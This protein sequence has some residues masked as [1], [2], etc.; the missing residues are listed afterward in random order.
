M[1][2]TNGC[3]QAL[4]T[5]LRRRSAVVLSS[6]PNRINRMPPASASPSVAT[7]KC[8]APLSLY[9]AGPHITGLNP[10]GPNT[11]VWRISVLLLIVARA[12]ATLAST[13]AGKRP[14]E[15]VE[16]GVVH[17]IVL[18]F[19]VRRLRQVKYRL[20]KRLVCLGST[21]VVGSSFSSGTGSSRSPPPHIAGASSSSRV[22][23]R[24]RMLIFQCVA[25]T[26]Y[27]G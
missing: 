17:G 12:S 10:M 22:A 3:W 21:T 4:S 15:Y 19:S 13:S 24:D 16:H 23:W 1:S 27:R 20:A 25:Q 11:T 18:S 9:F 8:Q 7:L 5:R 26:F 2:C 14:A 6:N